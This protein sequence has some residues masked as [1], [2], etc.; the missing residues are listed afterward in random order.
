MIESYG[1]TYVPTVGT[2]AGVR[3]PVMRYYG[4][5]ILFKRRESAEK[6]ARKV[7]GRDY[8]TISVKVQAGPYCSKLVHVIVEVY[9]GRLEISRT[10]GE[11]SVSLKDPYC[12]SYKKL[13]Q[14]LIASRKRTIYHAKEAEKKRLEWIRRTKRKSRGTAMFFSD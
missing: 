9:S 12:R 11:T 14:C 6:Y 5:A 3:I 7:F 1:I 10:K 13:L 4:F 8:S 2:F